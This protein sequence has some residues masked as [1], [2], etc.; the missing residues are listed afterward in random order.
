MN[1]FISV[2]VQ[3]LPAPNNLPNINNIA[4]LVNE[5]WT[6]TEPYLAITTLDDV[7]TNFASS[8]KT[9]KMVEAMLN[10]TPNFRITNGV[11]YLIPFNGVDAV[12][13]SFTT[14]NLV[15]NIT[16]IKAVN[17]GSITISINGTAYNL[18]ALDFTKISTTPLQALKDIANIVIKKLG[19]LS[20]LNLSKITYELVITSD[21][22]IAIKF[23][24]T[25]FGL[26]K[27]ITF[28]T[29]AGG[30]DLT[31]GTLLATD[32]G[33]AVSGANSSGTNIVDALN[34][35]EATLTDL[36]RIYFNGFITTQKL[37]ATYDNGILKTI[38]DYTTSKKRM[39]VYGV[40]SSDDYIQANKI[41]TGLHSLFRLLLIDIQ[42]D[43]TFKS[44]LLARGYSN[45]LQP[46]QAFTM[47]KKRLV[48][49][50]PSYIY[51]KALLELYKATADWI[52]YNNGFIEY[53][54]NNANGYID[55]KLEI[56]IIDNR[57]LTTQD[58]LNT[59]TKIPQTPSGVNVI[60]KAIIDILTPLRLNG[61][62]A[63]DLNWQGQIPQEIILLNIQDIFA[64]EIRAN[65]FFILPED[66]QLQGQSRSERTINVAIYIQKAGAI[67]KININVLVS[68]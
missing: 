50:Q 7:K 28:S 37:E 8:T 15:D 1:E 27:N 14:I 32:D 10:Q 16:A 3:T 59:N 18:T 61:I 34:A 53:V 30:T 41:I 63:T 2:S 33:S 12:N 11:L 60:K 51:T 9:Y 35:F 64:N 31:L 25:S 66:I 36:N 46:G 29:L 17:N 62:I 23:L 49:L 39:F 40:S 22:D 6:S 54:S 45:N 13:G 58:A 38:A 24:S 4:L 20:P 68:N 48:G 57:L 56:Q 47:N 52:T 55:E 5:V 42:Q 65:G 19:A 44:A 43:N 21:T 26:G 67:H